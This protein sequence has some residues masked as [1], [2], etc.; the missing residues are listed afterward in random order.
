MEAPWGD[1]N[2][3]SYD[4]FGI[5]QWMLRN[6]A[7][8]EISLYKKLKIAGESQKFVVSPANFF[9]FDRI[10]LRRLS[11]LFWLIPR[12]LAYSRSDLPSK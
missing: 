1:A 2:D 6:T 8:S 10:F 4:F 7:F 9:S 12:I 11:V 3:N 5:E